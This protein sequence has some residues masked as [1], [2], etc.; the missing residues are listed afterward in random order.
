MASRAICVLNSPWRT[1]I[2]IGTFTEATVQV[3]CMVQVH[4]DLF[5]WRDWTARRGNQRVMNDRL[6]AKWTGATVH[7]Y[8]PATI[9]HAGL[10]SAS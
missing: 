4:A 7:F 1:H 9:T 10:K 3:M 6:V 5:L 2:S 8:L